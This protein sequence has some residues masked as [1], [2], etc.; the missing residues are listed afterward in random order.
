[1]FLG[2]QLEGLLVH[3]P[4]GFQPPGG[5]LYGVFVYLKAHPWTQPRL[6]HQNLT[7]ARIWVQQLLVRRLLVHLKLSDS[8]FAVLRYRLMSQT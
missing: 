2:R 8:N 3:L 7:G 1:M 4:S 6:P 5:G